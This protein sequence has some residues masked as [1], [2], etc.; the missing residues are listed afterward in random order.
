MAKI[1]ALLALLAFLLLPAAARAEQAGTM[2]F[3][4]VSKE[5]E[6]YDGATWYSVAISIPLGSC[7][8]EGTMDYD[9]LLLSYKYCDGTFWVRVIGVPTLALCSKAGEMEFSGGTFLVCNG[10]LWTNI[11][12][13]PISS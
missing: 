7:G 10:L 12:G 1:P 8:S 6:F 9:A 5:L 3:N 13:A 2:H 11:K 4:H